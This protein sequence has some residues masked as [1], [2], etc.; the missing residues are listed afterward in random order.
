MHSGP[1]WWGQ[2]SL[3][4]NNIVWAACDRK[5][6]KSSYLS[7]LIPLS[8]CHHANCP[9]GSIAQLVRLSPTTRGITGSSP[10]SGMTC[11]RWKLFLWRF[12]CV[13]TLIEE[14]FATVTWLNEN[15][16]LAQSSSF[17]R[18][19]GRKFSWS[20]FDCTEITVVLNE[21]YG[22]Y[23]HSIDDFLVDIT[24]WV[25][26]VHSSNRNHHGAISIK[27]YLIVKKTGRYKACYTWLNFTILVIFSL[28]CLSSCCEI[29]A[30]I[31]VV[32]CSILSIFNCAW[33]VLNSDIWSTFC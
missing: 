4:I 30:I 32:V 9:S 13:W 19:F 12:R 23:S 20:W 6:L 18:Q 28:Y 21:W 31:Y 8:Q 1:F 27:V 17:T 7:G 11:N 10:D 22:L 16:I 25:T 14:I 33:I 5:I 29:L 2:R 26:T 24:C 3:Q 15:V